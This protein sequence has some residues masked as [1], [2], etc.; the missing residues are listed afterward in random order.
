VDIVV[1]NLPVQLADNC[2]TSVL[3]TVEQTSSLKHS[4][5][6]A[7][8]LL[9][10]VLIEVMSSPQPV[11]INAESRKHGALADAALGGLGKR[12]C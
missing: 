12:V 1:N 2:I 9:V 3:M 7:P 11:T 6:S 4:P 5:L 8:E 10:P